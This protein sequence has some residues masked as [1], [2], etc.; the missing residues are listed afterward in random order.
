[1]KIRHLFSATAFLLLVSFMPASSFAQSKNLN[2]W[3]LMKSENGIEIYSQRVSCNIEGAPNSFDYITFKVLNNSSVSQ[4][5]GLQFQIHFEE[6]CNGCQGKDETYTEVKL[7]P[8]QSIEGSCSE[9]E[10][11][12]AYFILNP[13]FADSW[14][15]THSEVLIQPIK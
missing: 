8:G 15:Y 5:L 7:N 1:M 11:K 12:L 9:M 13:S 6:G 2:G 4:N 3:Q 14:K 10:N